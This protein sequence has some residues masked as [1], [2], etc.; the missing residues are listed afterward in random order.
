[1]LIQSVTCNNA[2]G[3]LHAASVSWKG[4][5]AA[6]FLIKILAA[7]PIQFQD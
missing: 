3:M 1:M 6:S 5:T 2:A 4:R 7:K